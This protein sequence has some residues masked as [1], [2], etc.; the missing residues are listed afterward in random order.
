MQKVKIFVIFF[1]VGLDF[2]R[3]SQKS[4]TI[5]PFLEGVSL[6]RR[7]FDEHQ[8]QNIQRVLGGQT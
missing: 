6:S 8:V 3:N 7:A 2:R 1:Y 4:S 5:K